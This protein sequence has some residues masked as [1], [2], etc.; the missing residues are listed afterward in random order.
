MPCHHAWPAQPSPALRRQDETLNASLN[1]SW[2]GLGWGCLQVGSGLF[3]LPQLSH[4]SHAQVLDPD[5]NDHDNDGTP[6][7]RQVARSLAAIRAAALAARPAYHR[8]SQRGPLALFAS[9]PCRCK[10]HSSRPRLECGTWYVTLVTTAPY[11]QPISPWTNKVEPSTGAIP[12]FSAK[13]LG[14]GAL[15]FLLHLFFSFFSLLV[16]CVPSF[17]IVTPY[18][19]DRHEPHSSQTTLPHHPSWQ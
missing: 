6:A 10:S 11:Q 7:A 16:F 13:S 8:L 14:R 9:C 4:S 2:A 17:H 18:T 1:T 19:P 15:P 12:A 5:V 3:C